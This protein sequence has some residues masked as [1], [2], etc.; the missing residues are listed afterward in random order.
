METTVSSFSLSTT[1]FSELCP[2]WLEH[3]IRIDARNVI[4]IFIQCTK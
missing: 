2:V 3:H 4:F 1:M